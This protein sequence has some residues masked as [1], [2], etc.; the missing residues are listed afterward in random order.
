MLPSYDG[1]I[2]E[3]VEKTILNKNFLEKV[4]QMI[5]DHHPFKNTKATDRIIERRI[6]KVTSTETIDTVNVILLRCVPR[7]IVIKDRNM[8]IHLQNRSKIEIVTL[9]NIQPWN[10]MTLWSCAEITEFIFIGGN[11]FTRTLY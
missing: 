5:E 6:I 2:W 1:P 3:D 11:L 8:Y 10:G 7:E 4:P 9:Y